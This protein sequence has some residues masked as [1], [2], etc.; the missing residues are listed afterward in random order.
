MTLKELLIL[1]PSD[2]E[3]LIT[4]EGD[5]STWLG[6]NVPYYSKRYDTFLV[7]DYEY[8]PV[9]LFSRDVDN[10]IPIGSNTAEYGIGIGL[11]GN[12]PFDEYGNLI[13]CNRQ[14]KRSRKK[15]IKEADAS[16]KTN[17]A[18]QVRD[19]NKG[20]TYLFTGT[21][22]KC[23]QLEQNIDAVLSYID[24]YDDPEEAESQ[25]EWLTDM[26]L[27]EYGCVEEI[28]TR[29]IDA[30]NNYHDSDTDRTYHIINDVAYDLYF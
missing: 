1:L 10:I 22:A 20:Y 3:V 6:N 18:V 4:F 19:M 28:Y 14:A 15:S 23:Q 7:R 30:N 21:K 12:T 24:E 25:I 27:P 8:L 5:G 26:V 9:C 11:V 2:T 13:E 29:M 16:T 17:Y